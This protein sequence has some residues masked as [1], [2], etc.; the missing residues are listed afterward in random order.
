M[1]FEMLKQDCREEGREK[2]REKSVIN[3]LKNGMEE[4]V[5]ANIAELNI[6]EVQRIKEKYNL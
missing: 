4:T 2:E 1:T 6:A 3:M 5:I